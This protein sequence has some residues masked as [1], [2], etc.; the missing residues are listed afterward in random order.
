M[1]ALL[2]MELVSASTLVYMCNKN[3]V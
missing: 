1:S 3:F 2:S